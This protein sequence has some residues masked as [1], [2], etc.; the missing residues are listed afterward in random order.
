M[1]GFQTRASVDPS[2]GVGVLGSKVAVSA[3]FAGRAD[4]AVVG[5]G[6]GG[7]PVVGGVAATDGAGGVGACAGT[8]GGGVS[9]LGLGADAGGGVGDVAGD[10]EATVAA[11]RITDGGG[12]GVPTAALVFAG[13][14]V[15]GAAA[16]GGVGAT[17]VA[18]SATFVAL[19]VSRSM[20]G[21]ASLW[22]V[23]RLSWRTS[24]S[25]VADEKVSSVKPGVGRLCTLMRPPDVTRSR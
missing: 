15:A 18:S 23:V 19:K 3:G 13:G 11:G 24:A 17:A 25:G 22:R 8:T 10:V 16:G 9:T 2:G 7:P 14:A 21:G 1:V 6:V 20:T 12:A 5:A 4:A